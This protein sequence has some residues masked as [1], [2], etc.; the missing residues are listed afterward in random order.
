MKQ[1]YARKEE[2]V[3]APFSHV[4]VSAETNVGSASVDRKFSY[5]AVELDK[6]LRQQLANI[7]NI[8]EDQKQN[9]RLFCEQMRT[10]FDHYTIPMLRNEHTSE[11]SSPWNFNLDYYCDTLSLTGPAYG[12]R[13]SETNRRRLATLLDFYETYKHLG[14]PQYC[15]NRIEYNQDCLPKESDFVPCFQLKF[16]PKDVEGFR[17]RIKAHRSELYGLIESSRTSMHVIPKW[18]GKTPAVDQELE[19][20]YSFSFLERLFAEHRTEKE[21]ILNGVARSIYYR[22]LKDKRCLP[23]YFIKTT[24]LWMCERFNVNDYHDVTEIAQKW[25][26]FAC[27]FLKQKHCPH[28]FIDGA[29]LFEP[30]PA[31]SL[32]E[33][34]RILANDV[35]LDEFFEMTILAPQQELVRK[36]RQHTS[37]F[38]SQLKV[39]DLLNAI[40]DY[41]QLR[42]NWPN[43]GQT[44]TSFTEEDAGE[45]VHILGVLRS[46]DGD[47]FQ[48]LSEFRRL[49]LDEEA[50]RCNNPPIWGESASVCSPS[51]FAN[52]LMA[53]VLYLQVASE[54][55]TNSPVTDQECGLN[56]HTFESY[57]NVMQDMSNPANR[58]Q[59]LLT[60]LAPWLS[61]NP[62]VLPSFTSRTVTDS[63]PHGPHLNFNPSAARDEPY[64]FQHWQTTK[65]ISMLESA[66]SPDMT[67]AEL[68]EHQQR[69][70]RQRQDA[71]ELQKNEDDLVQYALYLSLSSGTEN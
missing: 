38:V 10:I 43:Q 59:N 17:Q 13:L 50:N 5:K 47:N 57:R 22:Y 29:N 34:Y 21:Q 42:A 56:P 12:Y 33:A 65:L 53:V 39:R 68:E 71:I 69:V 19:L 70:N 26:A 44:Q 49:C 55:P 61:D 41:R 3:S 51:E 1:S 2:G 36:H 15:K 62:S 14:D 16:W 25:C 9:Y 45:C 54:A 63:H 37:T 18:S 28:Y 20:R 35:R 6:E 52:G 30:Y 32:E 24:V 60:A 46:M 48:N 67:V 23:S 7:P 64:G 11:P 40:E 27:E 66:P 31:E 4:T 8:T 58:A